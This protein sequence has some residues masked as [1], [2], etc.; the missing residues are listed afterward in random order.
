MS[1]LSIMI[2]IQIFEDVKNSHFWDGWFALFFSWPQVTRRVGWHDV[3]SIVKRV[4]LAR[5]AEPRVEPRNAGSSINGDAPRTGW[6]ILWKIPCINEWSG[7]TPI[8]GNLHVG[9][10][11]WNMLRIDTRWVYFFWLVRDCF[12]SGSSSSYGKFKGRHFW[13][14]KHALRRLMNENNAWVEHGCSNL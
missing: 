2:D 1:F 5:C 4:G 11:D 14:D 9:M 6:F 3:G 7:C 12:K 10:G 13:G 8:L